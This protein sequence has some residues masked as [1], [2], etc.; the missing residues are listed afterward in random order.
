MEQEN[1]ISYKITPEQAN[2]ICIHFGKNI[3]ELDEYQI[4]E[5][6]DRII[7]NLT[8]ID[9]TNIHDL[10]IAKNLAKGFKNALQPY[11][12]K[13]VPTIIKFSSR[14]SVNIKDSWYTIEYGE[15]RQIDNFD[16]VDINKERQN[17]I[18]DCNIE[19]DNQIKD[20]LNTFLK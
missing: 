4:C 3:K 15:E 12:S 1:Y 13:A 2:A 17:L 10:L 16:E 9:D 5:L 6:L 7:D 11:E 14:A 20:I 19:V 18:N 8:T